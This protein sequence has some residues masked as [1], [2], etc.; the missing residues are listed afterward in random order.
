[1]LQFIIVFL[2][3]WHWD[4]TGQMCSACLALEY[5]RP[6]CL[7][8]PVRPL[9]LCMLRFSC[10]KKFCSDIQHTLSLK[11]TLVVYMYRPLWS[12][13]WERKKIIAKTLRNHNL[14]STV[15]HFLFAFL[16]LTQICYNDHFKWLVLCV[17]LFFRRSLI[18]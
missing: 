13:Q 5:S 7:S 10:T 9:I 8:C 2:N 3:V 17:T 16:V 12:V 1:M 6:H 4:S 15:F 14:K 18:I 11:I